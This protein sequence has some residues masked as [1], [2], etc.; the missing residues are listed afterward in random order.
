ML[1]LELVLVPARAP[2]EWHGEAGFVTTEMLSRHGVGFGGDA[3]YF[4]CGPEPMMRA[5]SAALAHLGVHPAQI[6]Y[7]L[8]GLV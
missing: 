6:R 7:E 8:F 3:E 2:E 4:V 1:A 5:A